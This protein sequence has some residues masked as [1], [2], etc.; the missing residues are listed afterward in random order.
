MG[1]GWTL[2]ITPR[3]APGYASVDR[4]LFILYRYSQ[5]NIYIQYQK[6]FSITKWLYKEKQQA[7][8]YN[9]PWV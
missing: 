8:V 5:L 9:G 1:G 6:Y 7:L 2:K 3:H 4:Y